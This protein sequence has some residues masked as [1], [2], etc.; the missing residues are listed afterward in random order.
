VLA[1]HAISL[2]V[3]TVFGTI[4]FVRARRDLDKPLVPRTDPSG[5][6]RDGHRFGPR[7]EGTFNA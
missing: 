7:A 1:Y 5:L 2:W 3:P 4:A 6:D